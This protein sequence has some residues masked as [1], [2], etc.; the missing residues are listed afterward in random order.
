MDLISTD[1]TVSESVKK[2][3]A[4]CVEAG[5][6][7]LELLSVARQSKIYWCNCYWEVDDA[8]SFTCDT[9]I[10]ITLVL[11]LEKEACTREKEN[12]FGA[13][14]RRVES[15]SVLLLWN[16]SCELCS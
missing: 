2:I 12:K 1:L 11:N 9:S 5:M 10:S 15:V 13:V 6:I 8:L 3:Y 7:G 16:S 14:Q 4:V